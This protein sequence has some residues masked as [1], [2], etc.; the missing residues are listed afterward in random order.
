MGLLLMGVLWGVGMW[1]FLEIEVYLLCILMVFV[2]VGMN[3]G[4]V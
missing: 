3:V 2:I 1:M 4:V